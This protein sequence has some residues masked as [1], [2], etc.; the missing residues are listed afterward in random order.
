MGAVTTLTRTIEELT[1]LARTDELTALLNRRGFK[2]GYVASLADNVAA[3]IVCQN[4][5]PEKQQEFLVDRLQ[6]RSARQDQL[7]FVSFL[8]YDLDDFKDTNDTHGH[9]VGD[10]VLQ[11]AA[12][13]AGKALR[14]S[15]GHLGRLGGEEFAVFLPETN[16]T[17]AGVAAERIR[18]TIEEN[19]FSVQSAGQRVRLEQKVSIGVA[20]YDLEGI[21]TILGFTLGKEYAGVQLTNTILT[22][23]DLVKSLLLGS[24]LFNELALVLYKELAQRADGA[25]YVAKL[26]G[27]NKVVAYSDEVQEIL[28]QR[29]TIRTLYATLCLED[30]A[31]K[32]GKNIAQAQIVANGPDGIKL[33]SALLQEEGFSFLPEYIKGAIIT[34]LGSLNRRKPHQSAYRNR[35]EVTALADDL[36]RHIMID[37]GDSSGLG[38]LL[39]F[40]T[41][42]TTVR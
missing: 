16:S 34:D 36:Y 27:K 13:R 5:S 19:T 24:N 3:Y 22:K 31:Q 20:T 12:Q 9:T 15:D 8:G 29:D 25:L 30:E 1:E 17:G 28:K 7:Q 37:H 21:D 41:R 40:A 4:L 26:T 42:Y 6:G 11:V 14:G 33:S 10:A 32:I 35:R 18:S 39:T 2:E 23:V 38:Q